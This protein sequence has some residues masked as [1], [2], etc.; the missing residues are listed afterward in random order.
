MV[1]NNTGVYPASFYTPE[2][3]PNS[4][5]YGYRTDPN[6][7]FGVWESDTSLATKAEVLGFTRGNSHKAYPIALPKRERIINDTLAGVP[8]VISASDQSSEARA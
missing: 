5:Y 6:T 2:S 4:I 1:S 7:M 3:N 8:I